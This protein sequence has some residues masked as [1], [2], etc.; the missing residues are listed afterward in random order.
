[1]ERQG[2]EGREWRE[3]SPSVEG[4]PYV[5]GRQIVQA[6][7]S[8]EREDSPGVEREPNRENWRMEQR[9]KVRRDEDDAV[10]DTEEGMIQEFLDVRGREIRGRQQVAQA[11]MRESR[12]VEDFKEQL[13][14]WAGCCTFCRSTGLEVRD[15]QMEGCPD[16]GS[17]R[18][19]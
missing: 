11:A 1:M 8:V 16:R 15:H 4:S 14:S 10:V 6:S 13:E 5:E 3:D 19:L 2:R 9:Q 17:E 7:S 12:E 18:W